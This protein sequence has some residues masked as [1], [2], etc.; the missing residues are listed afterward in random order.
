MRAANH[1]LSELI[2]FLLAHPWLPAHFCAAVFAG[3]VSA[4]LVRSRRRKKPGGS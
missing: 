3:L 2:E 4:D 1:V